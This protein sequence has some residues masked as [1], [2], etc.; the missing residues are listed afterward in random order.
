[1][2][3]YV[4]GTI[5]YR[6]ITVVGAGWF[7]IKIMEDGGT[8][9]CTEFK[10][11]FEWGGECRWQMWVL[12]IAIEYSHFMNK[13]LKDQLDDQSIKVVVDNSNKLSKKTFNFGCIGYLL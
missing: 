7:N 13:T 8:A 4:A 3:F 10:I 11:L 6:A 9:A 5:D 2:L 12:Y 1:M